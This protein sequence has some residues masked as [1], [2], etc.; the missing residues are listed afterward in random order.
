MDNLPTAPITHI[1]MGVFSTTIYEEA[2]FFGLFV[3][4]VARICLDQLQ[5]T[6]VITRNIH[7]AHAHRAA[8]IV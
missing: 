4:V 7:S 8:V 1:I 3:S 6:Y 2:I 5:W